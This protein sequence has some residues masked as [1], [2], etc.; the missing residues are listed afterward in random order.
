MKYLGGEQTNPPIGKATAFHALENVAGA[1]RVALVLGRVAKIELGKVAVHMG[2]AHVVIGA[3]DAAL[4]DGEE[5]LGGV[6][7]IAVAA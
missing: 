2:S 7:V 6:A 5:I 1:F 4:E 3:D